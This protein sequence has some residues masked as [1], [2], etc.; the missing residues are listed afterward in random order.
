MKNKKKKNTPLTASLW[1]IQPIN[2]TKRCQRSQRVLCRIHKKRCKVKT[3]KIW[4]QKRSKKRKNKRLTV[5]LWTIKL[6]DR[7]KRCYCYGRD[8]FKGY[9]KRCQVKR[10]KNKSW[11]MKSQNKSWQIKRRKKLSQY[12][13]SQMTCKNNQRC[14]K[15]LLRPQIFHRRRPQNLKIQIKINKLNSENIEENKYKTS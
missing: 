12:K 5:K 4:Q 6:I 3:K 8:L 14:S 2:R 9:N 11:W 10:R 7:A 15:I 13:S 1:A